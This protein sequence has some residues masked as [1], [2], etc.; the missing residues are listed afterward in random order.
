MGMGMGLG[1][2]SSFDNGSSNWCSRCQGKE[3]VGS[4]SFYP[5]SSFY[6]LKDRLDNLEKVNKKQSRADKYIIQQSIQIGNNLVLDIVYQNCTN[7][8]GRKILVFK[9]MT[10]DKLLENNHQLIDPHFSKNTDYVSPFARME[11][12][13]EGLRYAKIFANSIN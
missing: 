3:V 5:Y 10:L 4:V 11:P 2:S 6:Q 8:E 12:T 9:H 1:S 7:Y 13:E